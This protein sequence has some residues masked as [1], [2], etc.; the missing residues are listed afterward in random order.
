M[1]ENAK[2][3]SRSSRELARVLT[4]DRELAVAVYAT[5]IHRSQL[6]RYSTGRGKPD[7]EHVGKL[8]RATEGTVAADGWETEASRG[9]A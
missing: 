7:A 4:E 6:W 9:A 2:R 5:G 1:S 8:H 3:E